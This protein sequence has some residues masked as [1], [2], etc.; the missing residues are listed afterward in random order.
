[1]KAIKWI[2]LILLFLLVLAAGSVA[3]LVAT[4]DPNDYKPQIAEQVKKATGRDL[5]I[6]GDINWSLFPWLGLDLGKTSLANPP[7]FSSPVF[8]ELDQ[9]QVH[10][11]LKP[12][13]K[14]QV[15]TRKILLKGVAVNLEKLASGKDN[16]SDLSQPAE[17][18]KPTEPATKSSREIPDFDIRIAGFELVDTRLTYTDHQAGTSVRIDPLNLKTGVLAL[19]K[20]VPVTADMVLYQDKLKVSLALSGDLT[21]D[22]KRGQYR[23]DHLVIKDTVSGKSLPGGSLTTVSKLDLQ[24]DLD[25]QT[26]VV[27]PLNVEVLGITLDGKVNVSK[28]MDAPAFSGEFKTSEF[29]PKVLMVK[30]DLP[31]PVTTDAKVLTRAALGFSVKGT[32]SSV[33]LKPL[34]ATLDDSTL[35]GAF[36]IADFAR[37]V[38]RFNLVLDQIDVDRYLPPVGEAPAADKP[39]GSAPV[40]SDEIVLPVEMLRSLDIKGTARVEKLIASKLHFENASV[41]LQARNGKLDIKPLS[42]DLYQGKATINAGLDVSGTTPKYRTTV[43]LGGVRSE[44][45]LQTLFGDRYISGTANFKA[46][47][48]TTGNSVSGLTKQL[49]GKFSARFTDGTIKG[50]RLSRKIHEAQNVLRKFAGKPPL[51]EDINEDTRFS[52]MQI[53]G[54]IAQGVISSDDLKIEA[55]IFQAKGKG[56]V[57]LPASTIDYTLL[58]GTPGA[59]DK[60]FNFLPLRISGPFANLKFQIKADAMAKARADAELARQKAKLKAR[61]DEEKARLEQQKAAKEAELRARAEAEKAKLKDKAAAEEARL[62]EKARA[63][64]DEL[65]QKLQDQLQNKLKGLFK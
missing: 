12:L 16:W 32:T 44:E 46:D 19:G 8:A 23:F 37:M 49:G 25:R 21:A 52:L 24:A 54:Q 27:D 57:N 64:E 15:Q 26:L 18:E 51:T 6:S 20:P 31:A 34:Q 11:A 7:G 17:T 45:I 56:R 62:R 35:S 60:K 28:M 29:D 43:D 61:L 65:K 59:K 58:L 30:L 3:V 53:S 42:A 22:I 9:V 50:S 55:P 47:I 13:L 2:F 41:T 40:A 36:S 38:M 63:K 33:Q 4:L 14:K 48:R 39:A 1:M 5:T 10:V